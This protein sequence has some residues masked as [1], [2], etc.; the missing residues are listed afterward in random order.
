ML[1]IPAIDILNGV[2]VRLRGGD[3]GEVSRYDDNPAAV[4]ERFLAAGAR[5]LHI[6]DLDAAKC[7]RPSNSSVI[8]DILSVVSRYGAEAEVGGGLRNEAAVESVFAAGA[9][10]AIL[11]T[12]AVQNADLRRRLIDCYPGQIIIGVD[13]RAGKVAVAGWCEDGGI[14]GEDFFNELRD[15]P[16][17]AVIYTDISK[18]G[19]LSGVDASAVSAMATCAPCPLIASGGVRDIDDIRALQAA[20]NIAGVVVGKALYD[21]SLPLSEALALSA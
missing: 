18:D 4:A 5:R 9:K 10:Y 15:T 20:G 2:C 14:S 13:T 1:V 19:M 7:G 17:A 8:R 21:N 6:V 3:Y 12:A 16:P 11:G